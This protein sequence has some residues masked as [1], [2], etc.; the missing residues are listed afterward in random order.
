MTNDPLLDALRLLPASNSTG[1][2]GLI[3]LLLESLT[4]QP[5]C[6]AK[7]GSQAGR[8]MS[9]RY[10]QSNVIAVECKRYK[11]STKLDIREL[12][13]EIDEN[14][15]EMPDLDIWVLVASRT[16]QDSDQLRTALTQK[17][18]KEGIDV[19]IIADDDETPSSIEVLCAYSLEILINFFRNNL[20][21]DKTELETKTLQ[22]LEI[23]IRSIKNNHLFSEKT[24]RLKEKFL[25]PLVGY[26]A[27]RV[28]QNNNFI[29]SISSQ[30]KSRSAFG[31]VL[32][33]KDK[34]V[35]FIERKNLSG[36]LDDWFSQWINHK[37]IFTLTGEEGDGKTWGVTHWLS[38]KINQNDHF[39]AVFFL[40]SI[41]VKNNE[42]PL[43]LFDE[44]WEKRVESW[45]KRAIV[46]SPLMILV[47]DG[48]NERNESGWWRKLIEKLSASPWS[49]HVGIII[50]CRSQYW[51]DNF[52][53]LRY[54]KFQKYELSPYNDEEL[55]KALRYC[56]LEYSIV[57]KLAPLI[58]KP[59]YFDLIVNYYQ[60][61]SES[62]DVTIA[63][64]IYE[65]WKD[66]YNRRNISLND[67]GFD[68]L[69]RGLADKH[70]KKIPLTSKNIEDSLP[71]SND[72]QE[73]FEEIKTGGILCKK[74]G[75]YKVEDK[76]LSYGLALLLV[77]SLQD[78]ID[79]ED[80]NSDNLLEHLKEFIASWLEPNAG[81]DIKAEIC[82]FA[83][84]IALENADISL[85]VKIALLSAWINN[86]NPRLDSEYEFI[87]Y[88]PQ[89]PESYIYLAPIFWSGN[90]QNSWGQELLMRGFLK[91]K[92]N[93]NVLEKLTEAIEE[94]LSLVNVY[95]FSSQRH[96]IKDVE[97]IHEEINQRVGFSITL[98]EKFSFC[99]Y[100]FIAI[101]D[102]EWMRLSRFALALISCF[103]RKNFISAITKGCLAE[104][105]MGYPNKYELF[106]WV[107]MTSPESLWE[108]IKSKVAQLLALNNPVAQLAA[109]YLLSFEGS[110]DAST[111]QQNIPKEVLP[112][113][114]WYEEHQKDPCKSWFSWD[115]KTCEIC[116][117][118]KDIPLHWIA[119]NLQKHCLDPNFEI[120]ENLKSELSQLLS[121]ISIESIWSTLQ[122][123]SD[124]HNFDEYEPS[125]CRYSSSEFADLV[126]QIF[127]NI[128]QRQI[129]NLRYLCFRLR[130][131]YFIF[132]VIQ[133]NSIWETWKKIDQKTFEIDDITETYLFEY[134]L[135]YL[136]AEQQI[137][138]FLARS[139]KAIDLLK[140]EN[141][142]KFID[143]DKLE[144]KF[145]SANASI[146]ENIL[147]RLLFFILP[148][149]AKIT[150][151]FFNKYIMPILEQGKGFT[152]ASALEV[153]YKSKN[154]DVIQKFI[155]SDWHWG[156]DFHPEENDWAS[157]ILSEFGQELSH[158]ELHHRIFPPYLGYAILCRGM[159]D[160]E[161]EKY[162]D[163]LLDIWFKLSSWPSLP[164]DFPH[165]EI[166]VSEDFYFTESIN[167]SD[168]YSVMA[169]RWTS[170]ESTWGGLS[171]DNFFSEPNQIN[172]QGE[173]LRKRLIKIREETREEQEKLGNHFFCEIIPKE[174]LKQIIKQQPNLINHWLQPIQPQEG[175]SSQKIIQLASTFYEVLCSALLEEEHQKSIDL[176][177]YLRKFD[178]K[179]ILKLQDTNIEFLDYS[180]FQ[181]QRSNFIE[182]EWQ[183]RL[184]NCQSDEE[185]M[186]IVICAYQGNGQEWI[187]SYAQ[188]K[189]LSSAPLDFCYGVTVLGFL[190]S[191][192]AYQ[193]LD[194]LLEEQ[195]DTWRKTLVKISLDRWQRNSWAK[196]W[197]TQFLKET[198]KILAWRSFRLFVKCTDR[199]FYLW[200]Q[201]VI[202]EHLSSEDIDLKLDFLRDNTDTL[203]NAMQ[204]NNEKE[205]R[206]NFLGYKIL[207]GQAWPW[208]EQNN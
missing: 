137:D 175:E 40:S 28:E 63:R 191:D 189:L 57:E 17:A 186:K 24:S 49:D 93:P 116:L 105:I 59:R 168:R 77:N 188:E 26:S 10:A 3:A 54:L 133:E 149:S 115:R 161:I 172:E 16:I 111:L 121:H 104:A 89:D 11:N 83:S 95:G 84:L 58:Y 4:G 176:Y 80:T 18:K 30:E 198:D 99:D 205:L 206:E 88:L 167:L 181:V 204:N 13:G 97:E 15:S 60:K 129:S 158:E 25:S 62:G 144:N 199:R 79:Q 100:E 203:K 72:K 192:S 33:I 151:E 73:I 113:N 208:M 55:K 185:L 52:E 122:Q 135:K 178:R 91:W 96:Q 31:Q 201:S 132:D 71:I 134:I 193:E 94:Y 179:I 118:R 200:K 165:I 184:E 128:T 44:Q 207:S 156:G 74:N 81:I 142:F 154:K 48:I 37:K 12:L 127:S 39:P 70:L 164:D 56:S 38:Q 20:L 173:S 169:Q 170:G 177:D 75:K 150:T 124:G 36:Q 90:N 130:E 138:L 148:H 34:E 159:K 23:F 120:P 78:K 197:F 166:S 146:D 32:N 157:L 174:V 68:E 41:N 47:L 85:Q 160:D 65:D 110:K 2:E 145:I 5:F 76:F 107:I 66:R 139:P 35:N 108:E 102:D 152:K 29:T 61:I 194:Q 123:C 19:H 103:S 119:Q 6:L 114:P 69:I 98:G 195:P 45:V 112:V 43:K 136:S 87:S 14:L 53:N 141:N 126:K 1:F 163:Y 180:L 92:D 7:A 171:E 86:Q 8:D 51:K 202:D 21:E 101:G 140:F 22:E 67:D 155:E 183:K 46:D 106:Q 190:Q 109:Y 131:H 42:D 117:D 9:S 182:K 143:L 153:I 50:T 196:Y 162:A 125:L 27:W 187:E 147:Q 82:Q 64:L